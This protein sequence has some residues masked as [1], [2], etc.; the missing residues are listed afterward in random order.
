MTDTNLFQK[1]YDLIDILK[2]EISSLSENL[3][4]LDTETLR[5]K[6]DS[7]LEE[8]SKLYSELDKNHLDKQKYSIYSPIQMRMRDIERMHGIGEIDFGSS[9]LVH[10]LGEQLVSIKIQMGQTYLGDLKLEIKKLEGKTSLSKNLNITDTKLPSE[11]EDAIRKANEC[12]ISGHYVQASVMLR[13]ALDFA[14]T[15]K[16][17]Q[18]GKRN[19]IYEDGLEKSLDQKI[20]LSLEFNLITN[21]DKADLADI[22]WYGNAGAHSKMQLAKEDI[23][24]MEKKLRKVI[25]QLNLKT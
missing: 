8:L 5:Q 10:S 7:D 22:K 19:E 14:I 24:N 12:Y 9:S 18:E 2:N 23:E 15:K 17:L 25:G 20:K 1:L 21:M 16:L 13:K 3:Y 11:V 4:K 6:I